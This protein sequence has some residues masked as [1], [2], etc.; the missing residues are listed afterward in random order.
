MFFQALLPTERT[1][2]QVVLTVVRVGDGVGID[3]LSPSVRQIVQVVLALTGGTG[4]SKR[5]FVNPTLW[6]LVLFCYRF[7][8]LVFP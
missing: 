2:S 3:R 8:S 1:M 6:F 5:P 4:P 7:R